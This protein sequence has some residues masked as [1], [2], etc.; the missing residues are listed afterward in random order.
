MEPHGEIRVA[1][2]SFDFGAILT[3]KQSLP[4][5]TI[6]DNSYARVEKPFAKPER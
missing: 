4:R 5:L 1:N 2:F 6:L 3:I